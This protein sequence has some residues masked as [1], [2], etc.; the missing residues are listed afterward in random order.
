MGV[1]CREGQLILLCS[2]PRHVEPGIQ[3]ESLLLNPS[4]LN[5][6]DQP[7]AL[8]GQALDSLA[9]LGSPAPPR[10]VPSG[11]AWERLRPGALVQAAGARWGRGRGL[12]R[13]AD[14]VPPSF[15]QPVLHRAHL[16]D[17][18]PPGPAHHGGGLQ[19]PCSEDLRGG[20]AGHQAHPH[21]QCQEVQ[22]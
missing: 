2:P 11:S 21:P 8:P 6:T 14:R 19:N 9:L 15:R 22:R 18:S 4:F 5:S 16:R 10:G 13:L 3:P 1:G 12:S 17:L 20:R 7:P